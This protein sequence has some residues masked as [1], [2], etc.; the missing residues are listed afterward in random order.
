MLLVSK[1][2]FDNEKSYSWQTAGIEDCQKDHEKNN[3][4][5]AVVRENSLETCILALILARKLYFLLIGSL[6]GRELGWCQLRIL[7]DLLGNHS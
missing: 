4:L 5:R 6:F 1:L 2:Q 7:S 3:P